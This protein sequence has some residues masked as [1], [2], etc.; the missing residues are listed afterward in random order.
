MA[1]GTDVTED[2]TEGTTGGTVGGTS[3]RTV[4][5]VTG[6]LPAGALGVT[7]AHEHLFLDTPA[8][9]GEGLD[10]PDRAV[11]EVLEAR[12]TGVGAIVELTPIGLGRRPDLMRA[13][14]EA[15][16]M[17][18]VAATGYHRDA[19]YPPGHW[20]LEAS[21]ETL[22]ERIVLDLREGMHPA[23]WLDPDLPPDPARAG[24]IKAGASHGRITPGEERRLRAAAAGSRATGAPI[25]VH[26]EAGTCGPEIL[27]LLAGEGVSTDRVA[28]AHIDRAP[29][30]GLHA[31]LAARG[32]TLLY[33]TVGK[34][35][36]GTDEERLDLIEALVAAGHVGRLL[37]GLDMGR[38]SYFRAHGGGPGMRYLM[39]TFVPRLGGRI[40]A[41]A[42]ETILVANPA[43]A[44][45]MAPVAEATVR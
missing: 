24:V 36:Y 13:V 12:A 37:V 3:A 15:T 7:D 2:M 40:G 31:E 10:D 33:D 30:P 32:V 1:M 23:D 42:V 43:R 6:P 35:K 18:I 21:L 8:Q 5:T 9:P 38:P 41:A 26:T 34:I 11:A 14:S 20:V 19:H 28:L 17:P 16:G 39:A 27:D 4:V 45:A 29:D 44:F 25:V 22:T